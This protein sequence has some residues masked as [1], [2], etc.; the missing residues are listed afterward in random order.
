[1]RLGSLVTTSMTLFIFLA[2]ANSDETPQANNA[3]LTL[4]RQHVRTDLIHHCLDCHGGKSTKGNFDISTREALM[5]SGF[6][7]ESVSV[8]SAQAGEPGQWAAY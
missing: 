4:F 2:T 6:V 8:L 3:G 5:E 1:M 7:G